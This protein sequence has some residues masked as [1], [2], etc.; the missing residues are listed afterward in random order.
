VKLWRIASAGPSWTA[1]DL[2][3]AGAANSPG[4]WNQRGE[5]VLYAASSL[6]LAVLETAAHMDDSGLPLNKYVVE[7]E[8]PAVVWR[9]RTTRATA[10][11]LKDWDA[12][13]HALASVTIGSRWY[14]SAKTPLLCVP[15]AIV[16]EEQTVIINCRHASAQ[17]INARIIRKFQYNTLFR[18]S[19]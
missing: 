10:E 19:D 15:S 8:V 16:P 17:A 13:P 9:T 3:G 5:F 4:R 12:I 7:L 6:A 1:N 11:L 14:V 18:G 2:S